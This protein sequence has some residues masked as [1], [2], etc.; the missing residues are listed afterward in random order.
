MTIL[1]ISRNACIYRLEFTL[2]GLP[3]SDSRPI[4]THAFPCYLWLSVLFGD[5]YNLGNG[6]VLE[7]VSTG[8]FFCVSTAFYYQCMTSFLLHR[9]STGR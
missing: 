2:K 5:I 7:G 3:K 1:N 6:D 9:A 4:Y 8:V